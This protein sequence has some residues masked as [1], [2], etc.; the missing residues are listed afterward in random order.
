[1][2][3]P[4]KLNLE[5][6][7]DI[8]SEYLRGD[9]T[10]TI[11]KKYGVDAGSIWYL[12]NKSGIRRRGHREAAKRKYEV[13]ETYFDKIDS[14]DKA[15]FLG[16]LYADGCNYTPGGQVLLVL[17]EDDKAL[18]EKL[19][20]L[21]HPNGRPLINRRGKQFTYR[22]KSYVSRNSCALL[23]SNTHISETLSKHGLV[24]AKSLILKFP[25]WMPK[26]L[27]NHFVRGY[28]DG[29]GSISLG[30]CQISI[31]IVGTEEFCL[32]LKAILN[33]TDIKS[34]V[35]RA[36]PRS[37]I[38]QLGIHGN[39]SGR[40]F[41]EWIYR[42]SNIFLERKHNKYLNIVQVIPKEKIK[43]EFCSVC[44]EK[45]T[46]KGYCQKHYYELIGKRIRRERYIKTKS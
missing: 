37:K 17:T 9:N 39:I 38:R 12:L 19:S 44:S 15:Y 20:L 31:S 14:P 18:L 46:Q 26:E 35:C 45:P 10:N 36:K 16:I 24:K 29:D 7:N 33:E 34:S 23:I 42:D 6:K 40:R 4:Q 41:L 21:V 22:G 32:Y 13:N 8:F 2:G 3:R 25:E 11:A 30:N 43:Q 5:F 27:I 1:M 28:F